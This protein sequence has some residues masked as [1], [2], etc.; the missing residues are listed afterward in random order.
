[1][2]GNSCRPCAAFGRP[3][4][5]PGW[6]GRCSDAAS[7]FPASRRAVPQGQAMLATPSLAIGPA[8]AAPGAVLLGA[9]TP[10]PTPG[11][12]D[13]PGFAAL[14]QRAVAGWGVAPAVA[15]G[16]PTAAADEP[17]A[18][19]EMAARPSCLAML[20]DS[21]DP[22]FTPAQ[23]AAK[24]KPATEEAAPTDPLED[25]AGPDATAT[26]QAEWPA[27]PS[28]P[29]QAA[30]PPMPV[31]PLERLAEAGGPAPPS[32]PVPAPAAPGLAPRE[33]GAAPAPE[34]PL[35]AHAAEF[36]LVTAA[37]K[38][39]LAV[40]VAESPRSPPAT[41]PRPSA[42][43]AEPP[44]A[45]PASMPIDPAA[46][47]SA[48]QK[49]AT[50]SRLDE[51]VA[52]PPP[53]VTTAATQPEAAR[54]F[55]A[56]ALPAGV[57]PMLRATA[58]PDEEAAAPEPP[59]QGPR[60]AMEAPAIPG[61]A[62]QSKTPKVQPGL[63]ESPAENLA[64]PVATASPAIFPPTVQARPAAP[65]PAV[66][67]PESALAIAR[68]ITEPF[69]PPPAPAAAAAPSEPAHVAPPSP[70]RQVL[71]LT[72][73]MLISPGTAPTLSVTLEP[74]EM[75]RLEIRVGRDAEG[76]T[77][78][79]IAERPETAALMQR[80]GRELQQGLAQSGIRLD[81]SAIRFETAA[82]GGQGVGQG[83]GQGAG[84]GSGQ[85]AGNPRDRAPGREPRRSP[86]RMDEADVPL[87][88]LDMRI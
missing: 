74:G 65:A 51:P 80:D 25:A 29:P 13:G 61:T 60:A 21:P 11:E 78:R 7:P 83:A 9:G 64:Q 52:P 30:P 8:A 3:A 17:T 81:A 85:G 43:T 48:G 19:P 72:I 66:R 16:N 6:H 37:A 82:P 5:R 14:V 18:Q 40:P 23:R 73:A 15:P 84:Q 33:A 32:L 10:P 63:P 28:L 22:A 68:P 4:A 35:A 1:M 34:T 70:T 55:A 27:L 36:P 59:A 56:L 38:P 45:G 24:A 41:E 71:P 47:A 75:G 46:P 49:P 53:P 26:C 62:P 69:A 39:P 87:S 44:L 58:R 77:L 79:L 31:V 57:V 42:A 20:L 67:G 54:R 88:L 86:G 2:A 76:T 50:A 12:A